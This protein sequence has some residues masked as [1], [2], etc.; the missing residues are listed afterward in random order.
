MEI[1][2]IL[3]LNSLKKFFV[4]AK[5]SILLRTSMLSVSLYKSSH[6]YRK[7]H[8]KN[9]MNLTRKSHI[10]FLLGLVSRLALAI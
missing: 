6:L 9:R 4:A 8:N 1:S 7:L 2:F 5:F 3:F 10:K